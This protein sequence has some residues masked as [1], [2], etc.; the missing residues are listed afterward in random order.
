MVDVDDSTDLEP[1]DNGIDFSQ[2]LPSPVEK[3]YIQKIP[4]FVPKPAPATLPDAAPSRSAFTSTNLQG[5]RSSPYM[6]RSPFVH[7]PERRLAPKRTIDTSQTDT[8]WPPTCA[9][10]ALQDPIPPIAANNSLGLEVDSQHIEYSQT[11]PFDDA[12]IENREPVSLSR[13]RQ[14]GNPVS[15]PNCRSPLVSLQIASALSALDL[16]DEGLRSVEATKYELGKQGAEYIARR[17]AEEQN[18]RQAKEKAAGTE[19]RGRSR[20]KKR[21][22]SYSSGSILG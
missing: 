21:T 9:R 2:D 19:E 13:K 10:K 12:D 6:H 22:A 5:L 4:P 3:V 7:I 1:L 16:P 11:P 14:V 15:P 17:L 20:A 8:V 18:R